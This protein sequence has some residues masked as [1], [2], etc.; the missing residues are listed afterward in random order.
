MPDI[1]FAVYD[2]TY[3]INFGNER[4]IFNLIDRTL[5]TKNIDGFGWWNAIN[6][7]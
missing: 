7:V 1:E 4:V 2:N 5:L 6:R 3:M